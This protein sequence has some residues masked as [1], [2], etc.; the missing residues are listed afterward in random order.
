M[1]ELKPFLTGLFF[2]TLFQANAQTG[3]INNISVQPRT[4]GSGMVDVHFNLSGEADS[5][6]I[7][8]EVSF[9]AG[10]TYTPI[11]INYLS[12][13]L[14]GVNPGSRHVVW[15]GYGSF[16]N[17]FSTQTRLKITAIPQGIILYENDFTTDPGIIVGTYNPNHP[18]NYF[19]YD[20]DSESILF[21]T[22]RTHISYGVYGG[23]PYWFDI[24]VITATDLSVEFDITFD[25]I[26][27]GYWGTYAIFLISNEVYD[28]ANAG[29][30]N[31]DYLTNALGVHIMLTTSEGKNSPTAFPL[32]LKDGIRYS[33]YT[34]STQTLPLHNLLTF[35]VTVTA[36]LL[37]L[38]TYNGNASIDFITYDLPENFSFD[39]NFT[40][41]I[42]LCGHGGLENQYTFPYLKG[43][44]NRIKIYD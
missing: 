1:P 35:K 43:K 40:K 10:N 25:E 17:E 23:Y 28:E 18:F 44:L 30:L 13:D 22:K 14:Q 27:D 7:L 20:N 34:N 8:M 9:D 12:G 16:P 6:N 15:D 21:S 32:V 5:Y 41:M 37:Y 42:Y 19:V 24:P 4:D 36:N 38:E 3:T 33:D 26:L 31:T 39:Y 29:L 2:I 11:P